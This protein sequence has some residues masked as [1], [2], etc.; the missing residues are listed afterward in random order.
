MSTQHCVSCTC[1]TSWT[2]LQVGTW[3]TLVRMRDPFNPE[4]YSTDGKNA[5]WAPSQDKLP[6]P[7]PSAQGIV[8]LVCGSN[9]QKMWGVTGYEKP[10]HWCLSAYKLLTG[11]D[12]PKST[13]TPTPSVPAPPPPPIPLGTSIALRRKHPFAAYYTSWNQPYSLD[14]LPDRIDIVCLAF[15]DPALSGYNGGVNLN[16][17]GFGYN[18]GPDKLKADIALLRSRGIQV[19][20]SLGGGTAGDWSNSM[21]V[22]K[23]VAFV[24]AFGLSG[25]DIDLEGSNS[26]DYN[27]SAKTSLLNVANRL[28]AALPKGQYLLTQAVWMNGIDTTNAIPT[29]QANLLD[30]L[31]KMTYDSNMT[32]VPYAETF[33]KFR[34]YFKGMMC[35]GLETPK[36]GWGN[37]VTTLDEVASVCNLVNGLDNAGIFVW[38]IGK[39]DSYPTS[40]DFIRTI[41]EKLQ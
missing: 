1:K 11:K 20:A 29:L 32:H 41:T 24:K 37:H 13:P 28:R 6:V 33:N 34:Q 14:R 16:G 22:D 8:P 7:S 23:I 19:L 25:V 12:Y 5:V 38:A 18:W 30:I 4:A 39:D 3:W 17:T 26:W 35:I 9:H 2:P 21:N 15:V 27:S 31:F 10:G 36:E 40:K